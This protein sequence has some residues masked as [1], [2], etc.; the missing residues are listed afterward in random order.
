MDVAQ[1]IRAWRHA[2][3]LTQERF[4]AHAGVPRRTLIGYENAEREPGTSSLAAIAR[5]GVN[6]TWLLTGEGEMRDAAREKPLQGKE[7]RV[8]A[9]EGLSLIHI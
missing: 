8:I 1:R 5:T 3:G 6:M 7:L 9:G 4:A 2:M